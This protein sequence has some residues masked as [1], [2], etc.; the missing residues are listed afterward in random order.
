[1]LLTVCVGKVLYRLKRHIL[2][3]RRKRLSLC[4]SCSKSSQ[5]YD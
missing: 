3:G 2:N 5:I 1:M 4:K